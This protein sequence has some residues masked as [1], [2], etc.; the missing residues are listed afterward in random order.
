M[1][2]NDSWA[3]RGR[4]RR[5][6]QR[7]LLGRALVRTMGFLRLS[8][9]P[10]RTRRLHLERPRRSQSQ[11]RLGRRTLARRTSAQIRPLQ[12]RKRP[13]GRLGRHRRVVGKTPVLRMGRSRQSQS[14]AHGDQT[15]ERFEKENERERKEIEVVLERNPPQTH[16]SCILK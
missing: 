5:R 16:T 3:D 15:Q 10:R 6:R 14:A 7:S 8:R 11:Q 13:L 2:T 12:R 9:S 4:R 1:K